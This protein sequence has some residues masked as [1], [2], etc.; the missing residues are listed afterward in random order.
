MRYI[1]VDGYLNPY[2]SDVP[3]IEKKVNKQ[4]QKG[5]TLYGNLIH[6]KNNEYTQAM[7]YTEKEIK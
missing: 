4:L 3:D 2:G 7:T 6:I 1:I 5:F